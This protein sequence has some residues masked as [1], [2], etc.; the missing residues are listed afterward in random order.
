MENPEHQLHAQ[1]AVEM[2]AAGKPPGSGV[3]VDRSRGEDSKQ[4]A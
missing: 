3:V 2:G 1:Q 4:G